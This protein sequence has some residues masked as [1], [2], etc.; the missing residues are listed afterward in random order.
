MSAEDKRKIEKLQEEKSKEQKKRKKE[1]KII[2]KERHELEISGSHGRSKEPFPA[3]EVMTPDK[4][5][6]NEKKTSSSFSISVGLRLYSP[7]FE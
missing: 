7:T 1:E 3:F 2:K 4:D 5:V 6:S